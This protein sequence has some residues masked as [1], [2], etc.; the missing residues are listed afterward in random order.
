M[1]HPR[2]KTT[3]PVV[4]TESL[5]EQAVK[6]AQQTQD[7][8]PVAQVLANHPALA[9]VVRDLSL[10]AAKDSG[11]SIPFAAGWAGMPLSPT[12]QNIQ[13]EDKN[14][15]NQDVPQ[16][17]ANARVLR[18]YADNN[19]WVRTA[20]NV[21]K[22]QISQAPL[23]IVPDDPKKPYN[24]PVMA[25]VEHLFR[26]PNRLRQNFGEL[27]ST[28]IE[29][30]LVLDQAVILK[31]MTVKRVPVELYALDAATIQTYIGWNGNP[32]EPRYLYKPVEI[33]GKSVPLRNDE[34][35]VMMANKATWRLGLSPVAV[36]R[37]TIERDMAATRSASDAISQKPPTSLIQIPGAATES[38][39]ALRSTYETEIAGKRQLMWVGGDSPINVHPLVFSLK[40]NQWMDWLTYIIR[41]IAVCFQIS[42]QQ[43]GLTG[44]VNRA[45]A[46]VNQDIAEDVGLI[47]LYLLVENYLNREILGDFAPKNRDGSD[48]FSALNLRILFPEVVEA[49]RLKHAHLASQ[50][51]QD[52]LAGLPSM[53]LNEVRAFRGQ[54]PVPQGDTYW[55]MTTQGPMPW[56]NYRDKTPET[57]PA[58]QPETPPLEPPAQ[59]QKRLTRSIHHFDADHLPAIPQARTEIQTMTQAHVH[60][61]L[62]SG[63][64]S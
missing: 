61:I 11:A 16:A 21:R 3:R 14:A 24:K 4:T 9:A 7:W 10:T 25:A 47:P 13:Q 51:A 64:A 57:A 60:T 45:T 28:L 41:Q 43:L 55:V 17:V 63:G 22:Q 32:D 18:I 53:T 27:L 49:S 54:D 58:P 1:K 26:N 29:D 31:N 38:L 35:I 42:P 19:P 56:L 33:L 6:I 52:S 39:R 37:E 5:L 62:T 50:L 20:I 40:D 8:K 15:W 2:K 30:L 44:D 23:T 12:L 36:L 48:N 59:Q 34:A 46:M